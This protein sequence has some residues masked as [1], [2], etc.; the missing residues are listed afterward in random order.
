[1]ITYP[2]YLA[3][4]QR[5]TMNNESAKV[6]NTLKEKQPSSK[7]LL[8]FHGKNYTRI[9]LCTLIVLFLGNLN[10]LVDAVMHPEIEYF[11]EEHLIVGG[12]IMIVTAVLLG[13]VSVYLL[14]LEKTIGE[15]NTLQ[16]LLPICSNC[17]KIRDTENTWHALE[18]YLSERSDILFT[19][20]I[21]PECYKKLYGD[22]QKKLF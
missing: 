8:P 16:G 13:I 21:C 18:N 14:R 2:L 22:L 17:K 12:V 1:M 15:L 5:K 9:S 6:S 20:S 7:K 4:F 3:K 19:H 11:D 10:A